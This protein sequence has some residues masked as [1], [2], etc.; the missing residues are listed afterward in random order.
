[1]AGGHEPGDHRA[2]VV[3][4]V[5]VDDDDLVGRRVRLAYECR[6]GA[7]K[8]RR[9]VVGAQHNRESQ[10]PVGSMTELPSHTP[11]GRR[12]AGR[13]IGAA[14]AAA[15]LTPRAVPLQV[16]AIES[17]GQV[18]RRQL[19]GGSDRGRSAGQDRSRPAEQAAHG[20]AE[21]V[22]RHARELP[23]ARRA[24]AAQ[25]AL[26]GAVPE[27]PRPEVALAEPIGVDGM[28][29]DQIGQ[30]LAAGAGIEQAQVH[31]LVLARTQAPVRA[32][33]QRGAVRAH[34]R[35]RRPRNHGVAAHQQAFEAVAV[36]H[37]I[38]AVVGAPE[39]RRIPGRKPRRECR[40]TAS[41]WP[42]RR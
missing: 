9:A 33:A 36:G 18:P 13:R 31:V 17:A 21:G 1:M 3:G 23:H 22:A 10:W 15:R 12:A 24:A 26:R 28:L 25:H 39:H 34:R 42:G 30:V 6:Q 37:R 2:R 11:K 40:P 27:T 8:P 32:R 16:T 4:R 35:E 5:V 38:G 14:G 19:S 7:G 29:H 20:V 41:A